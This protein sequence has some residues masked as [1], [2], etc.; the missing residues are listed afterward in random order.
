MFS[1]A[2]L[3]LDDRPSSTKFP[4]LLAGIG[5]VQLASASPENFPEILANAD[6]GIVSI[7]RWVYGGLLES[8]E[9]GLTLKE[10][11]H[12]LS[13]LGKFI[14]PLQIPNAAFSVLMRQAPSAF[15]ENE[16]ELADLI[17]QAS[18]AHKDPKRLKL[19]LAQIPKDRWKNYLKTRERNF[20]INRTAIH[21]VKEKAIDY[22]AITLDDLAESGLNQE[23]RRELEKEIRA[24][25]LG[26]SVLI[27]PGTDEIAMLLLA[28]LLLQRGARFPKICPIYSHPTPDRWKLRYE[29]RSLSR[30]LKE[31]V[32]V[33]GAKLTDDP[34]KSDLLLFIHAPQENQLDVP[35]DPMPAFFPAWLNE[36]ENA[37]KQ[38]KPSILAD[39][40]FANGA[41][42][43]MLERVSQHAPLSRLYGFSAWNT[44]AN[45]LGMALAQGVVR[46]LS[47]VTGEGS[48]IDH[49]SLLYLRFLED[50]LYQAEVRPKMIAEFKNKGQSSLRIPESK[51]AEVEEKIKRALQT[52]QNDLLKEHFPRFN[53]RQ[54]KLPWNRLFEISVTFETD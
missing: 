53:L 17:K 33:L 5:G 7:D 6:S 45:A 43:T 21:L 26:K 38:G 49:L 36:L 34:E 50:W 19:L 25:L 31:Q 48:E 2:Y 14:G 18:S 11:T 28:S 15:T 51:C 54:I 44:T 22:L 32:K 16:A 52:R 39:L 8:R 23:E 46:W 4:E 41:D 13:L 24:K 29:D 1:V 30:L 42:R 47:D 40:R 9:F 27:L 12:R 20:A 3:P 10:A 35:Q 37:V